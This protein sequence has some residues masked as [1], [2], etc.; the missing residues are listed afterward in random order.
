MDDRG[1]LNLPNEPRELR[2]RDRDRRLCER[3]GVGLGRRL[4]GY[5]CGMHWSDGG[6]RYMQTRARLA[7]CPW[8]TGASV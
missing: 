7:E 8:V 2:S 5:T 6:T 1:R 4:S 3:R